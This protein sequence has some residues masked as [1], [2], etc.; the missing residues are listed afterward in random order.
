MRLQVKDHIENCIKCFTY[1]VPSG[2]QEGELHIYD[3]STRPF[4]TLHIDHYGPLETTEREHKHIFIVIDA[5]TKY[6]LLYPVKFTTTKEV[7]THLKQYFQHFG[8]CK[9]IVSDRGSSLT[10]SDVFFLIM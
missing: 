8:T 6:V 3:K 7:I 1:S 2:K 4:E 9:R 5:F 10:S